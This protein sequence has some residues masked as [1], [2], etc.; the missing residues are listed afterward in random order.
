MTLLPS[1]LLRCIGCAADDAGFFCSKQKTAFSKQYYISNH[2]TRS[3]TLRAQSTTKCSLSRDHGNP[4]FHIIA[5]L[6]IT[7]S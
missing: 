5:W 6:L 7:T 2:L 1:A 3:L 4:S